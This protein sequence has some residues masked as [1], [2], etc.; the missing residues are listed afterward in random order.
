MSGTVTWARIDHANGLV[1]SVVD[2]GF[3]PLLTQDDI[4]ARDWQVGLPICIDGLVVSVGPY[5][6]D[7]FDLPDIRR[8]WLVVSSR[9]EEL[10]GNYVLEVQPLT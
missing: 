7:A 1:E 5:E 2:L 9:C 8:D 4:G 6:F 10:S 3:F